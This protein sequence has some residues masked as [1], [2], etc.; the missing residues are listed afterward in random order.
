MCDACGCDGPGLRHQHKLPVGEAVMDRNDRLAQINRDRFA[1]QGLFVLNLISSPGSGKT[2][3][4]EALARHFG[5][6]M[7]VIEGDVQT[8]RDA[9]RVSAAGSPAVQ[10]ETN[11]AC[12]LDAHSV[13]HALDRL[14]LDGVRL[15]VIENVGNLVCPSTYDL[16]EHE[17]MAILSLPEGDDKVLK[18]PALFHRV[19]MLLINKVD[20]LPYLDFDIP[21]AVAE[22]RSLNPAVQALEISATRGDG[23]ERLFAHLEGCLGA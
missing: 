4:L 23:M 14:E 3:V 19:K 20:L 12:H 8:S 18:Y 16:G 21:K 1:E 11:G 15:L 10:I 13:G 7:A 2:A 17:K 6:R 22:C 9:D 5:P